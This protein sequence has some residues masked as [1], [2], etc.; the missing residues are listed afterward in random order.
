M[1]D[2]NLIDIESCRL[3][4]GC[5]S[6]AEVLLTIWGSKGNTVL[7]LYNYLA[8]NRMIAAMRCIRNLGTKFSFSGHK[9]L[10]WLLL[11]SLFSCKRS[12]LKEVV[13]L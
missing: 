11:A 9:F 3:A 7:Q 12:A 10:N 5:G 1:K 13:Y 6:P 4:V 8:R 2:I